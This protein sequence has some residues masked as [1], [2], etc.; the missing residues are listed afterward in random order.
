MKT[1]YQIF[2]FLLTLLFC[3]SSAQ[4][5]ADSI[6]AKIEKT[7]IEGNLLLKATAT[8]NT[9]QYSELDYLFISIKRGGSGNLSNNK[10]SGKFTLNPNETK[11]LSQISVNLQKNDAVK[12]FLYIRDE[13]SQQLI[14]KDSLIIA[15]NSLTTDAKVR[16][17]DLFELKGLTIDD[18]KTKIGKDFYDLFYLE[19]SKLPEKYGSAV[20]I[21]ELPSIGRSSQI[22]VI[23]DDRN[24]YSFFS[25]PAEDFLKEQAGFVIK[26][27]ADYQQK[28]SLIK[29]EF[30][31]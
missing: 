9:K 28:K 17:T 26:V 11:I 24:L 12:I 5:L 31:Y 20:T 4:S 30:R 3:N 8:N 1:L 16:E 7:V 27:L 14:S 29:D 13:E 19:Y 22:S 15:A 18:T 23:I 6:T 21:S 10:Q 2:V 25:N